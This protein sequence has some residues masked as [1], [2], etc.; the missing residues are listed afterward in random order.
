M[1]PIDLVRMLRKKA[2]HATR[3]SDD[4]FSSLKG[5]P[6]EYALHTSRY[7]EAQAR[8]MQN[9]LTGLAATDCELPVTKS[10]SRLVTSCSDMALQT[11]AQ[12]LDRY[13]TEQ[14]AQIDG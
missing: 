11:A 3:I 14:S 10:A 7:L 9:I 6:P 4:V 1:V 2:D 8:E 12:A 13:S 5:I